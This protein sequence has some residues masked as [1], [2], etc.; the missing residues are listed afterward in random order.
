M[1]VLVLKVTNWRYA[2]KKCSCQEEEERRGG[3]K[4]RNITDWIL[5]RSPALLSASYDIVLRLHIHLSKE[6]RYTASALVTKYST[7]YLLWA[8]EVAVERAARRTE[9]RR[10]H[11]HQLFRRIHHFIQWEQELKLQIKHIEKDLQ[12]CIPDVMS[13]PCLN[14]QVHTEHHAIRWDS[15]RVQMECG[16][17]AYA[18]HTL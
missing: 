8:S 9:A 15:Y 4:R 16:N 12:T 13:C 5:W 6:G 1:E 14:A 10:S 18:E 2:F 7:Q 17:Y 11:R 3:E